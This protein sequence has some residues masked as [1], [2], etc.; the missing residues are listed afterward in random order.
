MTCAVALALALPGSTVARPG[1]PAPART[2][3]I[4]WSGRHGFAWLD[5]GVGAVAALGAVLVVQAVVS[6]PNRRRKR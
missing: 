5:A 1:H 4:V 6:P 3:V 2:L